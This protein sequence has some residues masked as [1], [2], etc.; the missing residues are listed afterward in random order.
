MISA[1]RSISERIWRR[2]RRNE[3]L[4]GDLDESRGSIDDEDVCCEIVQSSR[5]EYVMSW[6]W[7]KKINKFSKFGKTSSKNLKINEDFFL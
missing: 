7:R 6:K 3:L 5:S 2:R 1:F 4:Q